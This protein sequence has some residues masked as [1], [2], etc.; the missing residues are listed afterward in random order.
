MSSTTSLTS[1]SIR[2]RRPSFGS[3]RLFGTRW[4]SNIFDANGDPLS[5]RHSLVGDAPPTLDVPVLDSNTSHDEA[6]TK[7][8]LEGI[9]EVRVS[10]EIQRPLP[11]KLD[12]TS[13]ATPKSLH[14]PQVSSPLSRKDGS[15]SPPTISDNINTAGAQLNRLS[16]HSIPLKRKEIPTELLE[17]GGVLSS[18]SLTGPTD[19][20]SSSGHNHQEPASAP[21]LTVPGSP[22]EAS[23]ST[24]PESGVTSLENGQGDKTPTTNTHVLSVPA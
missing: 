8:A 24:N 6:F 5:H 16:T 2:S 20:F 3:V 11:P 13:S 14:N 19:A 17:I 23:A 15:A 1:P 10:Q 21:S 18:T 12:T 22:Q 4:G 7:S 9:A